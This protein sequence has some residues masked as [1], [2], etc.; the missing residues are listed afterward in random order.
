M[1]NHYIKKCMHIQFMW[2]TPSTNGSDQ[3]ASG[4][5]TQIASGG[6]INVSYTLPLTLCEIVMLV[7]ACS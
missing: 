6:F 1:C 4:Y 3:I 2:L 5:F 7:N